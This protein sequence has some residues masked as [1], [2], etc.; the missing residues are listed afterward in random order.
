MVMQFYGV[1][2]NLCNLTTQNMLWE[3]QRPHFT[4]KSVS[5]K[6]WIPYFVNR[7]SFSTRTIYTL[8]FKRTSKIDLKLVVLKYSSN[9]K[10]KCS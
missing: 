1:M 3:L 7:K 6:P 2:G 10:L 5:S 4:Q 9:F 8:F